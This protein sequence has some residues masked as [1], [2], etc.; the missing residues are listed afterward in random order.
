MAFHFLLTL[1]FWNMILTDVFQHQR[2]DEIYTPKH[3]RDKYIVCFWRHIYASL[4]SFLIDLTVSNLFGTK[5]SSKPSLTLKD[6][7]PRM[8]QVLNWIFYCI[9]KGNTIKCLRESTFL[10]VSGR[11]F[12]LPI[13]GCYLAIKLQRK[14]QS[15]RDSTH[16]EQWCGKRFHLMPSPRSHP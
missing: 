9:S 7:N 16:R 5:P 14:H 10:E 4:M 3:Y 2:W 13:P 12:F 15:D 8:W 1:S 6:E 11:I